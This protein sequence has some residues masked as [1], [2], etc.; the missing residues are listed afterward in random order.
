MR[1]K[2]TEEVHK[3]TLPGRKQ[4]FRLHDRHQEFIADIIE[5]EGITHDFSKGILGVHPLFDY[6]RKRY[7]NIS[8]AE[9]ILNPVVKHGEVQLAFPSLDQVRQTVKRE[10]QKLHPTTRR[11]MN[12]HTYKVSLGPELHR[13]TEAI[14]P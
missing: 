13:V 11:L 14:R 6:Q 9:S 4:L 7:D 5:L 1:A 10:I 8:S 12:A 3:M 2:L